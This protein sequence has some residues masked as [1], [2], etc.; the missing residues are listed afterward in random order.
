MVKKRSKGC[1]N[2]LKNNLFEKENL[3]KRQGQDTAIQIPSV[4]TIHQKR[5]IIQRVWISRSELFGTKH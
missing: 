2:K 5:K 3:Y 1:L 4:Q